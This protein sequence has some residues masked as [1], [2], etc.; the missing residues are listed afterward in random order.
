MK[1]LITFFKK[2]FTAQLRRCKLLI[3]AILFLLLGIMNPAVAKLTPWLMEIMADSLGEAGMTITITTVTAMDSWVQFFKNIPMALITFVL[4][5]SNIFTKEYR[6][7]TLILA[8]TKGLDRYKVVISKTAMLALLWTAGYWL[9]YGI[10]WICNAVLWDNSVAQ[11]LEFAATCW[12]V[13]GLF[14][15]TLIPLFST[16]FSANIGVLLGIGG[17]VFASSLIGLLPKVNKFMPTFLSDG[18]SLIY[19]AAEAETYMAALAITSGLCV[20]SFAA[21]IFLFNK[22]QL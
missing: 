14:T 20:L 1:V 4:L 19:G 11:N 13:F 2:E 3:L 17:V 22:K 10:T 6:Y 9:C 15:V 16:L 8:L 5:E 12:W 7:G 18:N 21:S